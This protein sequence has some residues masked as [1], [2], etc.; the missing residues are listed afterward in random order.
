M[1]LLV[2]I[3]WVAVNA[4]IGALIGKS[5]LG[6]PGDGAIVGGLLGPLGWLMLATCF[7]DTRKRC[8]ACR[9]IVDPRASIC[10]HCRSS[11]EG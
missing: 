10:P 1:G 9:G 6:R 7:S 11:L 8:P 2:I 3:S 4:T 5:C